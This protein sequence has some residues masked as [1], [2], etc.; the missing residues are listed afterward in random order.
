MSKIIIKGS[1]W[2]AVV[3]S[4]CFFVLGIWACYDAW[5]SGINS[6]RSDFVL[7]ILIGGVGF[8]LTL[9]FVTSK[10]EFTGDG[11]EHDADPE[12]D[13][14]YSYSYSGI[15]MK[16]SG[17]PVLTWNDVEKIICRPY[18]GNWGDMDFRVSIFYSNGQVI[19]I[20]DDE[21]WYFSSYAKRY[22][23]AY[24]P[25]SFSNAFTYYKQLGVE[26]S[27]KLLVPFLIKE[28]VLYKKP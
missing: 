3:F 7:G 21:V 25:E 5:A 24:D 15:F 10:Y 20:M 12:R 16:H 8:I 27:W 9:L 23:E 18:E 6:H 17:K 19:K 14:L 4:I 11:K 22:I 13:H 1:R 28:F 26:N 2:K